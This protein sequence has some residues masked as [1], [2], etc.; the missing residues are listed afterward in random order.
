MFGNFD[1][2]LLNNPEFKEDAVREVIIVPI[3]TRLGYSASGKDRIIRSKLLKHPFI[4]AGTKEYPV[5]IIPDYTLLNEEK[6]VLVLD[7]KSP[8]E[9]ILNKAHVQQAYSYAI[10]PEIKSQHFSLCNGRSLAVFSVDDAD[11]LLVV[12]FADYETKWDQIEKYLSPRFLLEPMLRKFA[13]D[14]GYAFMR[15]GLAPDAIIT[16]IDVHL[17]YFG[18]IDAETITASCNCDFAETPHMVNFDFHPR[19]LPEMLSGLPPQLSELFLE[20]LNRSPFQ[21]AGDLM[22]VVDLDATLGP[23]TQGQSETFVPL[24]ITRIFGS[25][26]DPMREA[27]E[28]SDIPPHIFRLSKAFQIRRR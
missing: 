28:P 2:A 15:L 5:K 18:R 14:L 1:S 3:L 23:E 16:M 4:Y 11:P 22:I 27:T 7:A 25:R 21:A 6:P 26:F 9:D 8:S 13:P 10:H 24:L 17:N 20:A 12:P 19:L